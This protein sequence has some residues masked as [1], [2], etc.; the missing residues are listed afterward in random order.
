MEPLRDESFEQKNPQFMKFEQEHPSYIYI[1]IY[2]ASLELELQEFPCNKILTRTRRK[3][4]YIQQYLSIINKIR[5]AYGILSLGG[6]FPRIKAWDP[7]EIQR[8]RF[9][10]QLNQ[11]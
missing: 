8:K 2:K 5:Q 3:W 10:I 9:K 4:N 11:R 1:Y 6:Y 7:V